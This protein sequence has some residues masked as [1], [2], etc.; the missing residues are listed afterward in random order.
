MPILPAEPECY[1]PDLWEHESAVKAQADSQWWC[2]HTKPR[3]EKSLARDLYNQRL[4]YYLPQV[5]REDYTPQGR[6]TRSIIPFFPS[7]LFLFGDE[8]ARVDALRGNRLVNVLNV[9]DQATLERDLRQIH[10]MLRSGLSVS[11][12]H[13]VSIGSKVKILTGPLEGIEGTVIR[14]GNRD[15][16]VAVVNFL[17]QG[18][19]VDLQDWQ[20]ERI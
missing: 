2:L 5:V 7:Y 10:Q 4:A 1:P 6:K 9:V 16:F 19:V 13:S 11:S 15:Q 17:R 20:V 12:A 14:R 8:R 18:A 3:Q